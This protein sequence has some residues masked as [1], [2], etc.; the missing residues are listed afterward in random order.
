[1]LKKVLIGLCATLLAHTAFADSLD[2]SKISYL[3]PIAPQNQYKP[4]ET[5]QQKE[6][7][8]NL[9]PQIAKDA[10]SLNIFGETLKWQPLSKVSRLTEPGLQAIKFSFSVDR[11][12]Q[13]DLKI[14]G[15]ETASVFINNVAITAND[16]KYPLILATGDHK[17]MVIT[18]QVSDWKKVTLDFEGKSEHDQITITTDKYHPL[19][20]KQLYDAKV[21]SGVALSPDSKQM[22]LSSKAYNDKSANKSIRT[23]QLLDTKSNTVR[24]RWEDGKASNFI[25]SPDNKKLVYLSNGKLKQLDRKTLA[26][27]MLSDNLTSTSGFEFFDN[28]TL[29]FNWNKSA[30]KDKSLT[31]HYKGLEDRWS[32]ARNSNQVHLLDLN[33]GLIRQVSSPKFNHNLEDHN[34]KRG[35]V[36]LSRNPINYAAPPHMITKLVEINLKDNNEKLIG[37]YRTFNNAQYHK[38]GFYITAGPAFMNGSGQNLPKNMLPN[39]YDSQLYKLSFNGKDVTALSKTFAPSIGRFEVLKNSDVV[40][41]VTEKDTK[42]VYLFDESK[43]SFKKLKSKLDIVERFS[44]SKGK[45]PRLLYTGTT[46]S[47]PQQVKLLNVYKNKTKTVSDSK[48]DFYQ[49]SEIATLEEF[50]FVNKNNVEISGRVYIPHNLDKTKKHPALIYYYGGTSPVTRGFTGRYP[51]N[52]WAANGYVVYVLQPTGATGFGQEFS[53]KH[54]NAWGNY[55]ADDIIQ[56]TGEFLKAYPFVDANKLGNLG[57]SY[58]GFMT[59]LLTTKTNIFSASISHAGISNITS[60][61]GQGWWGYLYS[62]EASKGSFPWNNTKLYSQHSPVYNADK[63]TTPL[64]LIHG[65]EDTNVPP[66]ESHNMYTALK[67]LNKDVELVEY[68]NANHQIFARDKRF[69]W[70]DTIMAYFDKNLKDQPQWWDYLYPSK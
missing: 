58:G 56:G 38:N 20:A 17:I 50:N 15:I 41:S 9:L 55:T 39:N 46:A 64:L 40:L 6:I 68:K 4:Y 47:K 62:G 57:A 21:I 25:W 49:N 29:I 70:W 7:I 63:V 18:E 5:A 1:M 43:N 51:F 24:Y 10:K 36:L 32:Y 44:L 61:W 69:H 37:E 14:Q 23:A 16:K 52:L 19:T 59:M 42:Q 60:Y 35:T 34:A 31:K 30:K 67:I 3:G 28:D 48:F 53:A 2:K 26:I 8:N 22:I 33:S 54:V 45:R 12:V 66:G 11:F 65:N 13:G 27:T